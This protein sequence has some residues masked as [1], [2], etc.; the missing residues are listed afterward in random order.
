MSVIGV[1]RRIKN[2]ACLQHKLK[3]GQCPKLQ[4]CCTYVVVEGRSLLQGCA[5]GGVWV[6]K[7]YTRVVLARAREQEWWRWRGSVTS[8][9]RWRSA[10][11]RPLCAGVAT[12]ARWSGPPATRITLEAGTEDE[13]SEDCGAYHK[14]FEDLGGYVS[15]DEKWGTSEVCGYLDLSGYC[16][17]TSHWWCHPSSTKWNHG[18]RED[19]AVDAPLSRKSLPYKA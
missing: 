5:P 18:G 15:M 19:T 2:T 12:A 6:W 8:P 7:A 13:Y 14:V 9:C 10:W 3:L 4:E 17:I 16:E 1:E 11:G